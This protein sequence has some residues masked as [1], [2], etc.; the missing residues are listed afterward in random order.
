MAK[1]SVCARQKHR[2]KSVALKWEKRK[3]LKETIRNPKTSDED[4]AQAVIDLNKLSPNS[5]AVRLRSRCQI[6]GRS[7]G[8]FK[9][10]GLSRLC[11]RELASQ[12][13]IPGITKSSW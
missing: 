3:N 13:M 9:K 12:G 10:F 2:E 11:F 6:T 4:R 5:S 7:R 8:V 1:K